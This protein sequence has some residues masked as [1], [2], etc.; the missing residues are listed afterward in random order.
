M[1][2]MHTSDWHLGRLFHKVHLTEDQRYTL[3]ALVNAAELADVDAVVISGDIY[4]R[5]VPPI[6]AVTLL[7]DI[8]GK[9]TLE[10][11]IPVVMIAGN[12]DSP[13]RIDYMSGLVGR[14]GLHVVGP[15]GGEPTGVPVTAKDGTTTTFWLLAY[16]D[17]ETARCELGNPEIHTHEAAIAAQIALIRERMDPTHSHVIVG[18]AFVTGAEESESERPLTVGGSGQVSSAVFDGF[19]YVALGHLHRP[20]QVTPKVRY[21]G[22]LLKYS[23]SEAEH[24]KS[25]TLVELV[26]GAD[27]NISTV[28]LPILRD[29][30]QISGT[31]DEL[32]TDPERLRYA[33]AYVE[34][35]LAEAAAVLEPMERLRAFYPHVLNLRREEDYLGDFEGLTAS[36]KTRTPDELFGAFFEDVT[37]CKLTEAQHEVLVDVLAELDRSEREVAS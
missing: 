15:V 17:P 26:N 28:E 11:Q 16:T 13:V 37:G 18:H 7:N 8:L 6:E 12:H 3:D 33:D 20:Q 23:F 30:V 22:S 19:D 32:T 5:A 4:D 31:F 1:R 34:I 36:A 24:D 21:S 9:L 10:L 14:M 2:F 27:P 35:T 29:V 25:V